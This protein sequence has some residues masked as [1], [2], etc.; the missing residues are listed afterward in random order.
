MSL[1][2]KEIK[3][4]R[5]Y[6]SF[7]SYRLPKGPK[8]FSKYI[9]LEKPS[10]RGLKE[11]ED[12]F[13]R[14]LIQRLSGK[15]YSNS[16]ITKDEVIK[17]L[18]FS[19]EF[20]KKYNGLTTPRRR[21]YDI[22]STVMFT[23][24][25]LITEEIDVDLTDI[26]NAFNKVRG[27]TLRE[28]ISKNM[29]RAVESIKYRHKLDANYLLELHRTIM[30]TFETK[31]PG[32]FRKKQ[33]YLYNRGS[34]GLFED[35]ELKYRPPQYDKVTKLLSEFFSWYSKSTLN[36]VEKATVAHYNLYKIH[37]FLDGNKRICRLIFNKTLLDNHFPLIN[38][39]ADKEAYFNALVA[40]VES[41]DSKPFVEFA[42]KQYY[43]QVRAFLNNK[44]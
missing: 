15:G 10:D 19:L 33:V 31:T 34:A 13:K 5:Y 2:I 11:I 12:A 20:N 32:K 6:Y 1:I 35:R 14:E 9:G 21:K 3:G 25:T 44:V 36:P 38:I 27:L 16:I 24:T 7:L 26:R 17:S 23:L 29:L 39:S 37:P 8:S 41:N 43:S 40:A 18:L 22:D 4:R 30:A 28:L 42:F